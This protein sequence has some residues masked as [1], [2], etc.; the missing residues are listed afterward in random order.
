M[1]KLLKV[2]RCQNMEEPEWFDGAVWS[3][4]PTP[5]QRSQYRSNRWADGACGP[6]AGCNEHYRDDLS[7]VPADGCVTGLGLVLAVVAVLVIPVWAFISLL[8]PAITA[9]FR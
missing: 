1:A 2:E 9:N 8:G 7:K 4:E 3:G 6:V 5:K